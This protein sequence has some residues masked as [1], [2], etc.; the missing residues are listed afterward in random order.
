MI[1]ILKIHRLMWGVDYDIRIIDYWGNG[2]CLEWSHF[3]LAW[4]RS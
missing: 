2:Y 1:K 4:V 3:H